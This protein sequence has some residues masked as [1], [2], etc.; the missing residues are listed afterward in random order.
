MSSEVKHAPDTRGIYQ[1]DI[2]NHLV[3]AITIIVFW[4]E[5]KTLKLVMHPLLLYSVIPELLT[6]LMA[7]SM[8][9]R[10]KA[11]VG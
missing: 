2:A 8:F 9:L 6:L 7:T 3:V 5:G 1:L 10:S 11:K 4:G